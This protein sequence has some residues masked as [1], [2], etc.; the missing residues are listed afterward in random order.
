MAE[1][2]NLLL[3]VQPI[4]SHLHLSRYDINSKFHETLA[5]Q[6]NIPDDHHVGVHL[7]KLLLGDVNA[8]RRRVQLIRLEALIAQV[9]R[10]GLIIGLIDTEVSFGCSAS[11]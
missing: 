11:K 6:A 8:V 1:T 3:L 10:E 4:G 2:P 7:L 5:R 9:D